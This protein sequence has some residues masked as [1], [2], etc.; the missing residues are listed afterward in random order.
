MIDSTLVAGVVTTDSIKRKYGWEVR[1][2]MDL[3]DSR[4]L[5][6]RTFKQASNLM[7]IANVSTKMA[8]GGMVSVSGNSHHVDFS[9]LL[10][11]QVVARVTKGTAEFFHDMQLRTHLQ[12]L[13]VDIR[14]Y[15]I[16]Q[17]ALR[18]GCKH[19]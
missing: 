18:T 17:H 12:Q 5:S 10:A 11:S 14:I 1:S 8:D 15:Y 4:Y 9:S 3:P 19:V 16:R 7:T 13:L 6:I 2:G